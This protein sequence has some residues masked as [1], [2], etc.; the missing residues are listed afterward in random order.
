MEGGFAETW[1]LAAARP[2]STPLVATV[3][4]YDPAGVLA[5]VNEPVSAPP[6]IEQV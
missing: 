6:K 1:K 2:E 5:T 3:I 4:E